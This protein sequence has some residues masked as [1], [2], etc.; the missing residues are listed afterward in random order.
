MYIF[1]KKSIILL[2]SFF[3]TISIPRVSSEYAL[4]CLSDLSDVVLVS[5]FYRMELPETIFSF[6]QYRNNWAWVFLFIFALGWLFSL[7]GTEKFK[8]IKF[9]TMLVSIF[10]INFFL[11]I[12]FQTRGNI[13]FLNVMVCVYSIFTL[14]YFYSF[15][16]AKL[17]TEK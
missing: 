7:Y 17:I 16:M 12:L 5:L 6:Y 1:F 2:V 3:L 10:F 9:A 4:E 8:K 13:P 15:L 14:Q 11:A